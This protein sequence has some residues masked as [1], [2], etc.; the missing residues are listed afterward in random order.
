MVNNALSMG[1]GGLRAMLSVHLETWG[2]LDCFF[3]PSLF[4]FSFYSSH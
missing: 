4:F 3:F 2:Y 1:M